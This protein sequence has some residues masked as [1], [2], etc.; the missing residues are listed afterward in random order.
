MTREVSAQGRF[1]R[2]L[3]LLLGVPGVLVAVIVAWW[4][5]WRVL[6][7]PY[8]AP[9]GD[10]F[11]AATGT[12]DWEGADGYCRK[13]PH[14]ITF[15]PDRS[16]MTFVSRE[17]WTDSSGAVHRTAEYDVQEHTAGRIR[18]RIRGETRMTAQG[19]PVVWDLVLVDADTYRWHRTDWP[20]GASTKPI[21]RCDSTTG[22]R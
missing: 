6:G 22:V 19:E 13:D 5:P 2:D 15:S 1:L 18:G 17:P 7:E 16:L 9:N 10:V 14:T 8:A 20:F 4:K 12:W 11:A 21:H 3:M